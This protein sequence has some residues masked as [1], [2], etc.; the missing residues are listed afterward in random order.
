M[1]EKTVLVA[2]SGGVDS[3][4]CGLLLR[5]A[6]YDCHGVMTRSPAAGAGHWRLHTGVWTAL[7]WGSVAR[8]PHE[9]TWR[10]TST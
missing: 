7:L 3:S 8:G 9:T 2:M 6:G 5:D 1:N 10:N 4:V